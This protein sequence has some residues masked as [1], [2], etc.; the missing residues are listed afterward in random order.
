[1]VYHLNEF[2]TLINYAKMPN[3]FLFII[4]GV[5]VLYI[6]TRQVTT[7]RKA[8]TLFLSY[9]IFTKPLTEQHGTGL[10]LI[11]MGIILKMIPDP[12]LPNRSN[13]EPQH[14]IPQNEDEE[15]PL[16]PDSAWLVARHAICFGRENY[17]FGLCRI[18]V[19][20]QN[21]ERVNSNELELLS[22]VAHA[23]VFVY[24]HISCNIVFK[25]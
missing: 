18:L 22:V 4:L 10:I 16:V 20:W 11:S 24:C 7:A 9:I 2:N 17:S 14:I 25:T 21:K 23:C 15:K 1:M 5:L 19:G 13:R 3:G 12:Q 6:K 8:L